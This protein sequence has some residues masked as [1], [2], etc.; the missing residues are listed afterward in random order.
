[1]EYINSLQSH[2]DTSQDAPVC[3]CA[4]PLRQ[5]PRRSET[6]GRASTQKSKLF[7]WPAGEHCRGLGLCYRS[8]LINQQLQYINK[9]APY[10]ANISQANRQVPAEQSI[11]PESERREMLEGA[12]CEA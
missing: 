7:V 3:V 12:R 10:R 1:M 6:S 9:C 2:I 8:H 5:R 11:T 4:A